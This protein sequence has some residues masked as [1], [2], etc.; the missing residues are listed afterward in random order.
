[1][2]LFPSKMLSYLKIHLHGLF[3]LWMSLTLL[4]LRE[5][6]SHAGSGYSLGRMRALGRV[7][8]GRVHAVVLVDLVELGDVEL[9]KLVF[10]FAFQ[11]T[12]RMRSGRWC[13][14][15]GRG[16]VFVFR[17]VFLCLRFL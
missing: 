11:F 5:L 16:W 2:T 17:R 7:G 1:M 14:H 15:R 3:F 12:C 4:R 13:W 10:A 8:S 9:G 6:F